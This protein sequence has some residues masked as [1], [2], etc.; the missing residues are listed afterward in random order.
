MNIKRIQATIR[1]LK[2]Y[3]SEYDT[4]FEEAVSEW[5]MPWSFS[6]LY[7]VVKTYRND[8]PSQDEICRLAGVN[9]SYW[10]RFINGEFREIQY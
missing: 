5:D 7:E 9:V 3:M 2:W 10:D 4:T 8:P 6:Y 1:D